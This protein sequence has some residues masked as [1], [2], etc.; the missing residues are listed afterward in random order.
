VTPVDEII[1]SKLEEKLDIDINFHKVP[2]VEN[3]CCVLL[4]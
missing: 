2:E 1:K 4:T 3:N